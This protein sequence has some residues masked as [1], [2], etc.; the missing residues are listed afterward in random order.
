VQL[1]KLEIHILIVAESQSIE[2]RFDLSVLQQSLSKTNGPTE[3]FSSQRWARHARSWSAGGQLLLARA[4]S[5]ESM[6]PPLREAGEGTEE[7]RCCAAG[8]PF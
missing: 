1:L 5:S 8:K 4:N 7:I 2:A 6:P 3:A